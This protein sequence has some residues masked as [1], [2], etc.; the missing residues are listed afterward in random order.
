MICE[1]PQ[2]EID[3]KCKEKVNDS[4]SE[5][6]SDLEPLIE[7]KAFPHQRFS[8]VSGIKTST[9]E[10]TC[11]P[12]PIK[13]RYGFFTHHEYESPHFYVPQILLFVAPVQ[14]SCTS[15]S[16]SVTFP[17]IVLESVFLLRYIK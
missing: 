5:S 2:P 9:G 16:F 3:L 11:R 10:V 15:I 6:Q 17:R 7:N 4:D 1:D 8:P 12:K 14:L 13:A